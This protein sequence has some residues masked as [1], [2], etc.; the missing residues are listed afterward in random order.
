L[1]FILLFL[2]LLLLLL[3]LLDL[4]VLTGTQ[5]LKQS[6]SE[7]VAEVSVVFKFF[8]E[9]GLLALCSNPQPGG[10]GLNIYIPWRIGGPVI[11]SGT[12]YIF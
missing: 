7:A 6:P 11:P 4:F 10:Q 5:G 1:I 9:T 3:L 8:I 12:E 2:L